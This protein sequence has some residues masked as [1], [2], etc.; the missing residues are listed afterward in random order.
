MGKIFDLLPEGQ[1]NAVSRK[2]L[3]TIT[4]LNDRELRREIASERREGALI[5]S[6]SDTKHNGYF[7]PAN[8]DELRRFVVSMT[9][10]GKRT[11]AAVAEARKVLKRIEAEKEGKADERTQT[12]KPTR[13]NDIL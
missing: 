2:D 12:E 5:I 10:R 6:S 4:G 3:A 1:E 7:R 8:A 11:F 9:N 13:R